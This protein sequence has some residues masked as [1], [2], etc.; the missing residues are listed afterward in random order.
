ML[1]VSNLN[2]KL[3]DKVITKKWLELHRSLNVAPDSIIDNDCISDDIFVKDIQEANKEF[4]FN[5]GSNPKTQD[6]YNQMHKDIETAPK[7]KAQSFTCQRG[8]KQQSKSD[9]GC[10]VRKPGTVLQKTTNRI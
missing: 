8:R 6:E 9:T 2:I 4:G 7:Y 3:L 5:W 10:L 1:Q